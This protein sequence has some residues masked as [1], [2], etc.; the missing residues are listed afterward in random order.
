MSLRSTPPAGSGA[1][2]ATALPAGRLAQLTRYYGAEL[3]GGRLDLA[4]VDTA[5][6]WH[7]RAHGDDRVDVWIICW[8]PGAATRLHDHGGSAGAFTVVEGS[9]TETVWSPL[10]GALL[11]RSH[12]ARTTL[13]FAA[14]RVHDVRNLD[15]QQTFSVHAYSPPLTR[16]TFFDASGD[17]LHPAMEFV[18]GDPEPV[19]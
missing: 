11:R 17:M 1:T 10:A 2:A 13:T 6:G 9:L 4:S 12:R 5:A 19:D 18:T 14:T 15:R 7:V 3:R 8:R 16:L